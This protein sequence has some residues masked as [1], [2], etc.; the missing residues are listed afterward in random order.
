[1]PLV[2]IAQAR[3]VRQEATRDLG[4]RRGPEVAQSSPA[5][6]GTPDTLVALSTG[7]RVN[8]LVNEFV[9]T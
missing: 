3:G 7:S 1:M 5:L 4:R 2:V 9:M 6:A 8:R